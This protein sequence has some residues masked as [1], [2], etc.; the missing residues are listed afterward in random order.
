M[1]E[2]KRLEKNKA[3]G[4]TKRETILRHSQM[5]CKSYTV[6]IQSNSLSK[7]QKE[8]LQLLF[9]EAKWFKNHV[10]NWYN[11]DKKK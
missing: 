10:L 3:I 1:N 11:L 8:Q 7:L 6:K 2:D 9:I 4:Q 5:D